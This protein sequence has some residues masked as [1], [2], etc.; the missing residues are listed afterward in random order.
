MPNVRQTG[1]RTTTLREIFACGI[2]I[3]GPLQLSIHV[4]Q[5]AKVALGQEKQRTLPFKIMHAFRW[6]CPRATFA[7]QHGGFVPREW[8]AAKGPFSSRN[9]NAINDC[10]PES[11]FQW[12]GIQNPVPEIQSPRR[13]IQ[14]PILSWPILAIRLSGKTTTIRIKTSPIS[15]V[16][17]F[18]ACRLHF[19]KLRVEVA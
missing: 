16:A 2:C 12:Q 5:N 11:K 1:F 17:L 18:V 8:K 13:E 15:F 14:N 4:V 7:S 10:N 19:K 3:I 9:P 6:S